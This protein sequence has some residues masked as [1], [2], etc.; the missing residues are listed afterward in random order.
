MRAI[1]YAEPGTGALRVAAVRRTS[2]K[3]LDVRVHLLEA[4]GATYRCI[5][6]SSDDLFSFSDARLLEA[7][8]I[9]HDGVC[10]L[11]FSDSMYGTHQRSNFLYIYFP[12]RKQLFLLS[13]HSNPSWFPE[14]PT[15]S[16][17]FEPEPPG[18]VREAIIAAATARGFLR[19]VEEDL[20]HPESAMR[21]WF[22]DN[23]HAPSGTIVVHEYDG[24]PAW[25][26]NATCIL[27]VG[28]AVWYAFFKGPL[29]HYDRR[30]DRH[31]VAYAPA[32]RYNWAKSPVWDGASLWFAIHIEAGLGRFHEASKI[33]QRIE[34][35]GD[36]VLPEVGE[37][38]FDDDERRLIING[39]I[40]INPDDVPL[41]PRF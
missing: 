33:L 14:P 37:L 40:K 35:V 28:D 6:S 15:P 7:E 30:R 10:E 1:E 34:Q 20:D 27:V 2:A 9:D 17:V 12:G 38:T 4:V 13:E 5:W 19:F 29:V 26:P 36:L 31:Y 41:Y 32:D 11:I 21:R 24:L 22:R 18:E 39:S 16:L 23:G 3:D 8:D 25:G